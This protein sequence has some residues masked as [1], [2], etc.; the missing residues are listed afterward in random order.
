MGLGIKLPLKLKFYDWGHHTCWNYTSILFL[1]SFSTNDQL[2][3]R[4]AEGSHLAPAA[5]KWIKD[6]NSTYKVVQFFF[7]FFFF[8]QPADSAKEYKISRR[9]CFQG[10]LTRC[11]EE[12]SLDSAGLRDMIHATVLDR[13]NEGCFARVDLWRLF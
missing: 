12:A 3:P 8:Y 2:T 5:C 7:F 1:F 13:E 10:T 11:R 9:Y 6:Q 4:V